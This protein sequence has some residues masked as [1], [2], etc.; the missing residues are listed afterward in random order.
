MYWIRVTR[1]A[2]VASALFVASAL[3]CPAG[4]PADGGAKAVRYPQCVL[5]IRHAE[6]TGEKDD[7]HLS[8]KGN[9]RAEVLDQL[10]VASAPRPNPFPKPDFI[11]AAKSHKESH[12]PVDT[13]APLAKKH[14]LTINETFDSKL[15]KEGMEKPKE[16]IPE[17]CDELLSGSKYAGKTVLISWRHSSIPDLARALKAGKVPE[18]WG[19]HVF[20]RVWQ[21]NYDDGGKAT[22]RDLPQRLLPMDSEK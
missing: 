1:L 10:F 19:D 21:I 20:D 14:K 2:V 22:F 7:A 11:F 5:I 16:G 17:L 18:K 6:K 13:V 9:E 15:P 3:L 12:R 8:K 4:A